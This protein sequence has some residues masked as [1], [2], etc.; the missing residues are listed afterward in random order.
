MTGQRRPDPLN[1]VLMTATLRPDTTFL[2]AAIMDSRDVW[3]P[4]ERTLIENMSNVIWLDC[5]RPQGVNHFTV[6]CTTAV[7]TMV[8]CAITKGDHYIPVVIVAED[9]F[10]QEIPDVLNRLTERDLD[11]KVVRPRDAAEVMYSMND[12][13]NV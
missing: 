6:L 13:D 4:V 3:N 12:L 7:A 11:I 2:V 1:S 5:S 10:L 8:S 9:S